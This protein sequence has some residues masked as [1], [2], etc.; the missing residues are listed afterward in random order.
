MKPKLCVVEE[1]A[2][3]MFD[4]ILI[5]KRYS[6]SREDLLKYIRSNFEELRLRNIDSLPKI[7]LPLQIF[8]LEIV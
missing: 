2:S 6:I 8:F 3:E 7:I 1:W 5:E 4:E